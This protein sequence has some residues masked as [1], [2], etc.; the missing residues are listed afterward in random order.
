MEI[1]FALVFSLCSRYTPC[2]PLSKE[3]QAM[4]T[5]ERIRSAQQEAI[6]LALKTAPEELL[7]GAADDEAGLEVL[8]AMLAHELAASHRLMQRIAAA[9]DDMLNY[10]EDVNGP[11]EA[12][13]LPVGDG[14]GD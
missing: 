10:S 11:D 14:A 12:S 3:H 1:H 2:L 5:K 6:D 9:G 13:D 7:A 8:A 4:T